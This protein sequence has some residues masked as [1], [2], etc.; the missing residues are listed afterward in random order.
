MNEVFLE[1]IKSYIPAEFDAFL[2]S[3]SRP[4]YQGLRINRR[5]W[6]DNGFETSLR[7]SP[8]CPSGYYID[9]PYGNHPLHWTG[10]FYL[11]EPSASGPVTVLDI[12]PDD[13][14]LDLC[15]APGG[16]STQIAEQLTNGFLISN[17]IDARRCQIL[18]SNMERMGFGNVAIT[19]DT[20]QNICHQFPATFD[21]ILVDAP[22]SGEGMMKK[23]NEALQQW[24]LERI[25]N[26]AR[27][28]KEILSHAYG[29]LKKNGILVYSTCTYAKEEN[30][31]VIEWFLST[32]KD[33]ELIKI[34]VP[35]GREGIGLQ[36]TRRVFPMDE[37]EGHFIAKLRKTGGEIRDPKRIKNQKPSKL[38]LSFLHE[39]LRVEPSYYYVNND[40]VYAMDQPFVDMKKVHCIRQGIYLGEMKKNRFEPSH[41]FYMQ[42]DWIDAFTHKVELDEHQMDQFMHGMEIALKTDKGFT[43]VCYKGL[44]FGFG[45]S[46]GNHIKNKIPKGIRFKMNSHIR[47]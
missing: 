19:N 29:A 37:G 34:D 32:Y 39:Q 30:E 46:D 33:M 21:K 1:R 23:H 4:M 44:P 24:S 41:A 9:A 26:C 7:R 18:L 35:F 36:K 14:V 13:I 45:K 25:E 43:A 12:Q 27:T 10:A 38:V 40:R 8:F 5:K 3:L 28:Q 6:K 17:E 42:A 47:L 2:Q 15:A 31:D 16:K 22:C 11:Q 20:V